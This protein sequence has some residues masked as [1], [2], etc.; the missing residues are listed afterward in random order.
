MFVNPFKSHDVS[1][2]PGVL[3][4]LD[5][6]PNRASPADHRAST[7]PTASDRGEIEKSEKEDKAGEPLRRPDSNASSGI[8]NHGMTVEAL[9]AEILADVAASDTDTPYDRKARRFHL[10]AD[11]TNRKQESRKS[12]TELSRIWAWVNTNGSYSPFAV[13][14]GW[15]TTCGFR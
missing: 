2:F 5:Q 4:P 6:T 10:V 7:A 3:Q 15:P 9:K 13:V 11:R 1:E 8:V 12:S 14:A